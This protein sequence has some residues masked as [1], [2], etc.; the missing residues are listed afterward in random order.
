MVN[1]LKG[2]Y[3]DY[4]TGDKLASIVERKIRLSLNAVK[5]NFGAD[6]ARELLTRKQFSLGNTH[7]FELVLIPGEKSADETIKEKLKLEL[8]KALYLDLRE[9]YSALTYAWL[10][11]EA[12][13]LLAGGEPAGG[14]SMFL[15]NYLIKAGLLSSSKVKA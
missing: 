4:Y 9:S 10:L 13:R 2:R 8:V 5:T 3:A 15:N 7:W 11:A 1:E 14:P 6:I 12:N